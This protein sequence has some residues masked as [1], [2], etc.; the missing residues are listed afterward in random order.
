M[1]HC[2]SREYNWHCSLRPSIRSSSSF[3][4]GA[5]TLASPW[6]R[7]GLLLQPQA[8]DKDQ[9]QQDARSA[10]CLRLSYLGLGQAQGW[11]Q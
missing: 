5:R 1:P 2:T 3:G 9:D 10:E 7:S 4:I 6:S 11:A 8:E